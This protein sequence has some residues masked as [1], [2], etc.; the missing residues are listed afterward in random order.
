MPP[1]SDPGDVRALT[2][3]IHALFGNAPPAPSPADEDRED[4]TWVA[5]S[6]RPLPDV[7]DPDPLLEAVSRYVLTAAADRQTAG[8]ALDQAIEDARGRHATR[9]MAQA[10]ESLARFASR[11]SKALD[12]ARRL[13]TVPVAILLVSRL[14]QGPD[15][16]SRSELVE[17]IPQL[18]P[19][20]PAAVLDALR[21]EVGAG[22]PDGPVLRALTDVVSAL[23]RQDAGLLETLVQDPDW[24]AVR[25]AIRVSA[26][27]G[28]DSALQIL[29]VALAHDHPRVR[30]EALSAL[31]KLGGGEAGELAVGMLA[32]RDPGVRAE[33]ART[34]GALNVARG[35]RPLLDRVETEEDP[36]VAKAAI[37]AAGL[38]GDPSAVLSLEK[39][40]TA[41][42]LGRS[43]VDVRVVAY[44]ALAAIGT[45]YASRLVDA[46]LED[47]EPEVREVAQAVVQARE[48]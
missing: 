44:E 36:E 25:M 18:G 31:A 37:R 6:G 45:P 14:G 41:T 7:A 4:V 46:A 40:A 11:E 13:V 24:R 17:L 23:A 9:P 43:P 35:L 27:R 30:I 26:E 20:V 12:R 47:K 2:R 19:E 10:A 15:D 48:D 42:L 33:A 16:A 1:G 34:V 32:D 22:D 39:R 8:A 5:E 21:S 38:M 29:M 3:T 28:G